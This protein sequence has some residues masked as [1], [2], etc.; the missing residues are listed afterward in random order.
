M[1]HAPAVV[2]VLSPGDVGMQDIGHVGAF[3]RV[4]ETLLWPRMALALD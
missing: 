4:A 2:Q 1:P 3:R